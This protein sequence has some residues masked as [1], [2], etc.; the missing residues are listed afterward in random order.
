M[1]N[2]S[3]PPEGD[4]FKGGLTRLSP[5][6]YQGQ[7]WVHW[8]TTVHKRKS[9]WL[10][11]LSH[12]KIREALLHALSRHNLVCA[13]YCLMPDYGHFLIGGLN[14]KPASAQRL[15]ITLFRKEW[16]RQ[17]KL[18]AGDFG[19]QK[20]AHD[21]VLRE[22]DYDRRNAFE[23]IAGYILEN[24]VRSG[25]AGHFGNWT[26]LGALVPGYPDLDPR[27]RDFW[28]RFWKIY[29]KRLEEEGSG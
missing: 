27:D 14:P 21:H 22:S 11:S 25:L 29:Y 1:E 13:C 26:F 18:I 2:P 6:A 10:T 9:G 20:Q 19:L 4:S 7:G 15:A 24:P 8:T 28:D 5:T 23:T 16:N 17:L 12:S 3:H